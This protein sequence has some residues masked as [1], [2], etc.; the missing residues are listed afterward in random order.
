MS[1]PDHDQAA[2][3]L[4]DWRRLRELMTPYIAGPK[5]PYLD[6]LAR[7]PDAERA[8]AG[9]ILARVSAEDPARARARREELLRLAEYET[10]AR[11]ILGRPHGA[12]LEREARKLLGTIERLRDNL[13]G[14]PSDDGSAN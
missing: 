4:R 9:A 11:E 3:A 6:A 2:A 10:K 7:M 5:E 13:A 8:E 1:T 14:F 12:A